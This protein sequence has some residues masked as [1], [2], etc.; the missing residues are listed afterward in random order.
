[1]RE[2]L[3]LANHQS[4]ASMKSE[5]FININYDYYTPARYEGGTQKGLITGFSI[6]TKRISNEDIDSNYNTENILQQIEKITFD[7]N[8]E[9]KLQT[10]EL[11]I[12]NRSRFSVSVEGLPKPRIFFYFE[13]EP[14]EFLDHWGSNKTF[15]GD[16]DFTNLNLDTKT[17]GEQ[18]YFFPLIEN[19]NFSL[20]EYNPLFGNS[21]DNRPSSDKQVADRDNLDINPV[22]LDSLIS[23]TATKAQIPDSNYSVTGLVNSRYEGSKT[24][25]TD[26]GGV[27]PSFTG[28]SFTGEV[29]SNVV[30]NT[31][32]SSSLEQDRVYKELFHS[33]ESELPTFTFVSSSF[34]V[35]N[36]TGTG[37]RIDI[38]QSPEFTGSRA[39]NPG[40]ILFLSGSPST[41]EFMRVIEVD[42]KNKKL[43]VE[44]K[45]LSDRNISSNLINH[46]G[47]KTIFLIQ[48]TKLFEFGS[49]TT[50]VELVENAKVLIK[51]SRLILETDKYGNVFTSSSIA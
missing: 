51:E 17:R 40:N 38:K 44:R 10:F 22:N 32:I 5:E 27:L 39:I 11:K 36:N 30:A 15:D 12:L 14:K 25:S 49:G 45:Y 2:D 24:D 48:P 18:V 13:V 9:N 31:K 47:S 23:G 20:N 4:I 8:F 37:T 16:T 7:I 3:F 21:I 43:I 26:F 19:V 34:D 46:V 28:R 1:M 33:G 35:D 6:S 50:K 29:F 42:N 41:Q